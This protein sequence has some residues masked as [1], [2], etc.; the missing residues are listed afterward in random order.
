MMAVC[1]RLNPKLIDLSEYRE[2]VVAVKIQP[3]IVICCYHRPYVHLFNTDVINDILDY[4]QREYQRHTILFVG[5]I[6]FPGIDWNTKAVKPLTPYKR[7][8]QN[9]LNV[10]NSYTMT[11]VVKGSTH[12]LGNTLDLICTNQPNVIFDTEII[13]LGLIDHSLIVAHVQ[14]ATTAT[15][16]KPQTFRLC[17][18]ANQEAFQEAMQKTSDALAVLEDPEEMW[19]FFMENLHRSIGLHLPIKQLKSL[20]PSVSEWFNKKAMKINERVRKAHRRS[21]VNS[22]SFDR[23]QYKK[24]R[25]DGKKELEVI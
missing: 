19:N 2:E 11:Q 7:I 9:F 18:K 1:D 15:L 17:K 3:R 16:R 10:L 25:R 13:S 12:L 24:L 22:N 6:N 21:K 8:H 5:D 14:S 23:E 20:H 4:L